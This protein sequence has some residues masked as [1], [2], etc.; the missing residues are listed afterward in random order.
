MNTNAV[1]Q[2]PPKVLAPNFAG[3]PDELK[4]I[5]NWVL[6]RYLPPKS[7][8]GKWRKVPF[9]PGGSSASSTDP[10]TWSRFDECCIAYEQGGFSGIG[11]VFDGQPDENGFV[12]A[13][14][15]FDTQA[16][17]GEGSLRIA[18]WIDTLGSYVETSV[19]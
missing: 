14:V 10:L 17:A 9:Q 15:D 6:W 18:E 2:S 19:S 1:A 13:G 11:F 5:K 3:I 8:E 12:F 4:Q 16:F 7:S